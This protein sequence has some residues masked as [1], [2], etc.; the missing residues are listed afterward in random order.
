MSTTW[1]TAIPFSP[2]KAS[3]LHRRQMSEDLAFF[4]QRKEVR[5]KGAARLED[6]RG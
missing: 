1:I 4:S 5:A 3:S 2:S 6:H